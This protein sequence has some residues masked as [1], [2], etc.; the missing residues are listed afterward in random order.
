MTDS[1]PI[2]QKYTVEILSYLN[3]NRKCRVKDVKSLLGSTQKINITIDT[4][5]QY[6]L[7]KSTR[8]Q[9]FNTKYL[10]LSERGKDVLTFMDNINALLSDDE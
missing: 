7:I 10:E 2:F 8:G 4:L 9:R 6:G 3:D 1:H 5:I